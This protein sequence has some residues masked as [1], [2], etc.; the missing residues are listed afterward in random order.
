[1]CH[2]VLNPT[3]LQFVC[4]SLP[5]QPQY[6]KYSTNTPTIIII[7]AAV[8]FV[9]VVKRANFREILYCSSCCFCTSFS[10]FILSH[11]VCQNVSHTHTHYILQ[12]IAY[13]HVQ[14]PKCY[15]RPYKQTE[16]HSLNHTHTHTHSSDLG[17]S[18]NICNVPSPK[19]LTTRI[20]KKQRDYVCLRV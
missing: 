1:M 8:V 6:A 18:S 11:N 5:P 17:N 7:I 20:V 12:C 2:K 19:G 15:I 4:S 13:Q 3:I 16:R 9:I 14:Q 10:F